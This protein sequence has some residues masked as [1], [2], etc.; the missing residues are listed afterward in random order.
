M[1]RVECDVARKEHARPTFIDC[2]ARYI[3]QSRGKRS[4]SAEGEDR[5]VRR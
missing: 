1:A 3:E 5:L 4:D 2:A